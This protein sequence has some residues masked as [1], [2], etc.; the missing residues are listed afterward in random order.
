MKFSCGKCER[1][2]PEEALVA[3]PQGGPDICPACLSRVADRQNPVGPAVRKGESGALGTART[4][5]V[6][7]RVGVTP[8]F[9]GQG[10]SIA[11]AGY[12][13]ADPL[14]YVA[15]C[16]INSHFDASLLCLRR[17]I[18]PPQPEPPK[19]LG[20]WPQLGELKPYQVG[21]Y[22]EWL[23]GGR[24][25]PNVDIGYVF[26]Y[27]YGLERRSVVDGQD[28][29]AIGYELLRLLNTY[30]ASRSFR[31][32]ATSLLIHLV[33]TNRLRPTTKLISKLLDHQD[34]HISSQL[35]AMLLGHLARERKGLP[36]DWALHLAKQD[37][38]AV[39]SVVAATVPTELMKLFGKKY[40]K[41][42]GDG[43]VPQ[44]SGGTT[45][46]EYRPASPTLLPIMWTGKRILAEEW[47]TIIGWRH[48]FSGV[49]GCY[50]ECIE[51][52]RSYARK[53]KTS[54]K[55]SPLSYE[56][57]PAALR[58]ET[59]H[60]LQDAW[61]ALI[62][63]FA[64]EKGPILLPISRLAQARGIA[65]RPKLTAS[66]ASSLA[67]LAE[68][69][70]SALEPDPRYTRK[71]YTWNQN[72]AVLRLP[73]RPL[74]PNGQNYAAATMVLRLALEIAS[75]DDTVDNNERQAIASFLAERFSLC[76]NDCLRLEALIALNVEEESLLAG[77]K[78]NLASFAAEQREAVAR[79]LVEIAAVSGGVVSAE[80][81]ALER[82]FA[83]LGL[84]RPLVMTYLQEMGLVGGDTPVLAQRATSDS[85]G[86]RIPS[87][88]LVLDLEKIRQKRQESEE[89]AR[90][91]VSVM[92]ATAVAEEE[93]EEV[94]SPARVSTV[95][96]PE[97][98]DGDTLHQLE[99]SLRAV[100]S[101]VVER[102]T[103]PRV[104][105]DEIVRKHG[106]M[107]AAAID[108]LNEWSDE[109]FGD[110]LLQD[111]D[112]VVVSQ[113]IARK[114]RGNS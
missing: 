41:E 24:N 11:V 28:I 30:G 98:R 25:D 45:S 61:D 10:Q 34:N 93:P 54:G 15:D 86:E 37:E 17:R 29:V 94:S 14:I 75:A 53:T 43:L 88:P 79:F 5:S 105:L 96:E 18:D 12:S 55:D 21:I 84:P 20:Y 82:T 63:E 16:T 109:Q 1:L 8:Q 42:Y 103:W 7:V 27:F 87:R 44:L 102:P 113:D 2:F 60:P 106:F 57:L 13:L 77:L 32:Y 80:I 110:F 100:L 50:N 66:Q 99:A 97:S 33:L 114:I 91:L 22:L 65:K 76:R 64:P 31:D 48:Q 49:V 39:R 89:A 6:Q 85:G 95:V 46:V 52:L 104:E 68:A 40:E 47:P 67:E 51:E 71:A 108:R 19:S 83:V 111:G 9:V 90:M 35:L 92:T 70:G 38:R 3:D 72:V 81:K 4:P 73:D 101:E 107:R 69:L 36:T 23:A 58:T 112:P 26:L 74:V 62:A 56:A 78:K 59:K